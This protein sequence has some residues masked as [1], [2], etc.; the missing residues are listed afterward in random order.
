VEDEQGQENKY[1]L[2]KF[3]RSNAGTCVKQDPIVHL[4]EKVHKG[5]VLADVLQV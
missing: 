3:I 4:G 1:D 2:L 5:E